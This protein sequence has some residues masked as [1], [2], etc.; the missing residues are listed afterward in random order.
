V[1][2]KTL[3]DKLITQSL[4]E[5]DRARKYKKGRIAQWQANEDL[6]FGKKPPTIPH[7]SNVMLPKMQGFENTLLSKIRSFPALKYLKG[8]E[9]DLKKA[10]RMTALLEQ[11]A[12]PTNGNW[13]FKDLMGKKSAIR[14][15]RAVFEYYA[16]SKDG[17]KAH[18][19]N[20]SVYDFL[21]DP[22]AGGIDI[23]LAL[24]LGRTGIYLNSTQIKNGVKDGKYLRT[25]SHK[26]INE[27]SNT[28][29][30]AEEQKN[31][32]NRYF[33]LIGTPR[34]STSSDLYKFWRW[35]TTYEGERYMLLL[36]EQGKTA[37]RVEKLTDEFESGYWPFLTWA[38]D[39]DLDEFWTP[40]PDDGVREIFMAQTV[41]VNQMLD[42]NEDINNPMKG[43]DVDKVVDSS[44]LNK[45]RGGLI[46]FKK[47]TNINQAVQ[48]FEAKPIANG[49]TVYEQLDKIQQLE[50]GVTAESRGISDEDKVAIYEGNQANIADRLGLLNDSY[51][52]FYHRLLMLH[53]EGVKEHMSKKTAIAMI[54]INGVEIEE[55]TKSDLIPDHTKF[56][57]YISASDAEMRNDIGLKRAKLQYAANHKD[58]PRI[59]Q[60]VLAEV[61]AEIAGWE[62]DDIKRL[63]DVDEF[64]DAEL[65]SE[66]AR[67]IQ[68]IITGE[69]VKPNEAA[70][71]A[72]KQKIVDYLRDKGEN[73]KDEQKLSLIA[74]V[75]AIEPYVIRNTVRKASEVNA[76][77]GNLALMQDLGMN[78]QPP[79][80]QLN[81]QPDE[82]E[83]TPA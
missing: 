26:L 31:K 22:G 49:V 60:K 55:V 39:P 78:E 75:E 69:E 28:D 6:V 24:N 14:Y 56:D 54:G 5:I 45:R 64:G 68:R 59:N 72:Y 17:Y 27:G 20:V 3:R 15:G 62:A 67:D 37:I 4:D 32:D 8:E 43:Y 25:E 71:V 29:E 30:N 11:S 73:L 12:K 48:V 74:Y 83:L 23:E 41:V 7:R 19:N 77:A 13:K 58:D 70:N 53:E 42:N 66:C 76:Q 16:E 33:A 9:S 44:L 10:K 57:Y 21:I 34:H 65:M 47:D 80:D 79:Q 46:P 2:P 35:F 81:L 36:N 82:T 52:N 50:S 51:A 40:G 61:E 63:M 1:L 18:F 38:T